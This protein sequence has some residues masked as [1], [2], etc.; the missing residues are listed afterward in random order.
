MAGEGFVLLLSL[1]KPLK[2]GQWENGGSFW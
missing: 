1:R 2:V